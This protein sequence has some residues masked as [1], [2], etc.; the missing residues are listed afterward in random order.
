MFQTIG[1]QDSGFWCCI[2]STSLVS[3]CSTPK[4]PTRSWPQTP[5]YASRSWPRRPVSSWR[6]SAARCCGPW[7][8][9]DRRWPRWVAC[10]ASALAWCRGVSHMGKHGED[11]R[12]GCPC[13]WVISRYHMGEIGRWAEQRPNGLWVEPWD[14]NDLCDYSMRIQGTKAQVTPRMDG[15][16]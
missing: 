16:D 13:F 4:I 8:P 12:F 2:F 6:S 10:C 9:P 7:S 15:W 11:G 14:L 5:P 3:L 1:F